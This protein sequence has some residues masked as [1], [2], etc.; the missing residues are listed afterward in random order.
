MGVEI[1]AEASVGTLPTFTFNDPPEVSGIQRP[2]DLVALAASF[3]PTTGGTQLIITGS[4]YG[5]CMVF[6]PNPGRCL[7]EYPAHTHSCVHAHVFTF[8]SLHF[9]RLFLQSTLAR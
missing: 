4:N 1:D 3:G 5:P 7:G 8:R 2:G 9:L 6:F